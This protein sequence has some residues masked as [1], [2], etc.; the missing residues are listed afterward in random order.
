MTPQEV[1]DIPMQDNNA[2]AITIR[3]YLKMLL[4]TLWEGK[5]SF[6]GKRPFGTCCWELEL[7]R[8]LVT[9]GA[10]EGKIEVIEGDTYYQYNQKQCD[11]LVSAA[12][13]AL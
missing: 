8:A 12:I 6:S 10:A 11:E 4:A 2:K 1:L 9:A 3:D 5:D 7:Y 13:D